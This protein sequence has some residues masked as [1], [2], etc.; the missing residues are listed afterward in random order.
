M[1]SGSSCR[2]ASDIAD[3]CALKGKKVAAVEGSTS[4]DNIKAQAATCGFELDGLITFRRH[5]DAVKALLEGKV[6]VFT[7]DAL[8]LQAYAE[9]RPLKVVGNPFSEEAY[10]FAVA[11]GD[12]RLLQLIDKT[13]REME[14]DGTY[15]A[16]YKRWFGDAIPPYLGD[17]ASAPVAQA[18]LASSAPAAVEPGAGASGTGETYVVQ[19][20]DTLSKIARKYYGQEWATS[21]QRIFEANRDVIGDDPA[22]L[23]VGMALE[24]PK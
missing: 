18:A 5:E 21:W 17:E 20:G 23:K 3:V 8:A 7:S 13:L 4:L 1:A 14:R 10:G 9:G 16:I 6:D 11:K 24:I 15:A 2:T 12:A 19:P 22:R